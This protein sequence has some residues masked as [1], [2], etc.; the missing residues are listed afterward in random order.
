MGIQAIP[1]QGEVQFQG[2][3]LYVLS[4]LP[5]RV[6]S[7]VN[8]SIVN[9]SMKALLLHEIEIIWVE[10]RKKEIDFDRTGFTYKISDS[11]I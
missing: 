9:L 2:S 7:Y 3:T 8:I 11:S 10:E 6:H 4:V 5:F 1:L